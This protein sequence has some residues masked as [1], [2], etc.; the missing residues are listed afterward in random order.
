MTRPIRI[1]SWNIAR[2]TE[3][4]YE[5]L[6][7]GADI[8]LLQEAAEPPADVRERITVGSEA[9]TT[10]GD[11]SGRTRKWRT[12]IV[13]LTDRVEVEWMRPGRVGDEQPGELA[14]SRHGTL[15]AATVSA[16]GYEP[17]FVASMYAVWENPQ[18]L[19]QG[20]WIYS[21]ASAHRLISD[22]SALIGTQR[23]HRILAAGD[24]NILH[25]HGEHGSR[26]WA[27][28]FESV[29]SRMAALGLPFIGP[30]APNGR[31]ADPWPDELPLGSRNVPTHHDNRQNPTT[32]TRQLD[33]VFASRDFAD[34]VAV[35]ALN[36]P[37][38]WGPSDH[39]RLEIEVS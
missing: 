34:S 21:D 33:F 24:L 26:Y 36:D 15:A 23:R 6:D 27:A 30:Q 28:R 19:A 29:F 10:A 3:P 11:H 39:C 18:E 2:R 8:A 35:R 4:W 22:L 7:T 38:Q 1:V 32:A 20:S 9:W 31:Q 37:E 5:L 25:G 17:F 14:V 16:P 12:A 13:A